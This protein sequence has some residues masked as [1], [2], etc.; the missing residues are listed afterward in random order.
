MVPQQQ[1]RS[2]SAPQLPQDWADL[3]FSGPTTTM[4]AQG[5]GRGVYL[6]VLLPAE[7][8]KAVGETRESLKASF[9]K[10]RIQLHWLW[11][12]W[13]I[14]F[15]VNCFRVEWQEGGSLPMEKCIFWFSGETPREL[16][17]PGPRVGMWT[18]SLNTNA[19]R[20]WQAAS[21]P[22]EFLEILS[23]TPLL[24]DIRCQRVSFSFRLAPALLK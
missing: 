6:Q 8:D 22:Q 13:A 7:T 19:H 10:H 2:L 17:L 5:C 16:C 12:F 18:S 14:S 11:C 1:W 23:C 3:A 4:R 9:Y 24:T 15:L 20:L 21:L